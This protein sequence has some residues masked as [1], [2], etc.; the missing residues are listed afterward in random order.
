MFATIPSAVQHVRSGRLKA[1]A[2]SSKKRSTGLPDIPTVAESGYPNFD[3][4]SWFGLVGPASMPKA[5]TD[6]IS[7]DIARVLAMPE[8]RAKF[9]EQGAEPV[10]STPQEFGKYMKDETVKWANVVKISGATAE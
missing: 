1:L 3:A 4:S 5:V 9:I 2:L 8:I 6:K 10:G 7:A